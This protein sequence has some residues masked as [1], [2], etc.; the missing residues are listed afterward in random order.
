MAALRALRIDAVRMGSAPPKLADVPRRVVE[1]LR[2]AAAL[3]E[4]AFGAWGN[5]HPGPGSCVLLTADRVEAL[6]AGKPAL[7]RVC[8]AQEMRLEEE[9]ALFA[10]LGR[11]HPRVEFSLPAPSGRG[12][13][14]AYCPRGCLE[15]GRWFR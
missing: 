9:G 6:L 13:D 10:A 14:P 8:V 4:L 7:R 15:H 12:C 3:T 1:L 11:R 2:A 5:Q